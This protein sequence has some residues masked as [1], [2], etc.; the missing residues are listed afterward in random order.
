MLKMANIVS[1]ERC[2]SVKIARQERAALAEV[3][4]RDRTVR[5]ESSWKRN[6]SVQ[7]IASV[8]SVNESPYGVLRILFS[9]SVF[10]VRVFWRSLYT[11]KIRDSKYEAT[12]LC[13]KRMSFIAVPTS[14]PDAAV[15]EE[16]TWA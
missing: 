16:I 12:F 3:F 7:Q 9:A 14:S 2:Q 10:G 11:P 1:E 15:E 6:V 4:I 13:C 5:A 8:L